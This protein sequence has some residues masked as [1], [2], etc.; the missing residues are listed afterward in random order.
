MPKRLR[1]LLIVVFCILIITVPLESEALFGV[2]QPF[3]GYV[4]LVLPCTCSP[5]NWLVTYAP[6]FPLAYPYVTH[7]LVLLPATIRYDYVQFLRTPAPT[8]WHLGWFIPTVSII[9]PCLMGVPPACL[10]M[11][12]DGIITATGSSYPGFPPVTP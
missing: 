2:V 9:S 8:S 10:P 12:A 4:L 11:P 3:G 7:S 6:L 1:I 5:G